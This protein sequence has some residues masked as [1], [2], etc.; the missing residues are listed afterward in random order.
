[1][2][3]VFGRETFFSFKDTV[4]LRMTAQGKPE[5]SNSGTEV[6]FAE[7]DSGEG[8]GRGEGGV[9]G[10]VNRRCGRGS[11]R[12]AKNTQRKQAKITPKVSHQTLNIVPRSHTGEGF[13]SSTPP[14]GGG[15]GGGVTPC[16]SSRLSRS[17]ARSHANATHDT[18]QWRSQGVKQ[19]RRS[20]TPLKRR[21]AARQ[22]SCSSSV[23]SSCQE[24]QRPLEA[25]QG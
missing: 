16:Q 14:P 24:G 10:H 20:C 12:T 3:N 15:G 8:G 25:G 4:D 13:I 5:P 17:L 6:L 7:S 2:E 11:G 21:L 9:R 19:L 23:C 22:H 18:Q 1:M